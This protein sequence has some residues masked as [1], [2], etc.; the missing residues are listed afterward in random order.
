MSYRA[1]AALAGCSS[2]SLANQMPTVVSQPPLSSS[3]VA[4]LLAPP[5]LALPPPV[6]L[7]VAAYLAANSLASAIWRLLVSMS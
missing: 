5:P 3:A 1:N 6:G 7:K 4:P 2:V